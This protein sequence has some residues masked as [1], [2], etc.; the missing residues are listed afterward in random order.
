MYYAFCRFLYSD[1]SP[2]ASAPSTAPACDAGGM[3]AWHVLQLENL[4]A[5]KQPKHAKAYPWNTRIQLSS[6]F[7][8]HKNISST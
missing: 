7:I 8:R 6:S 5:P 2:L 1:M 3:D 4:T